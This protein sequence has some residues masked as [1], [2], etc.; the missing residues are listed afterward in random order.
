MS[1]EAPKAPACSDPW[2]LAFLQLAAYAKA[3]LLGT[4]DNGLLDVRDKTRFA[5]VT[6]E[7]LTSELNKL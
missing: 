3:N 5:I 2:D 6:A 1:A 4:G 7:A